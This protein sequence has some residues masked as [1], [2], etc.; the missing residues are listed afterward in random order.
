MNEIIRCIGCGSV[1]QSEKKEQPG[2]LPERL[3]KS[4]VMTPEAS[5]YCQR[6]FRLRHYNEIQPVDIAHHDF[7]ALLNT[8]ASKKALIVNVVDLFDFNNSLI[9]SLKRFI[10]DNDLSLNPI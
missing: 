5:I 4:A 7:L 6:C 9:P 2:Y 10:G 3:L 8:L 1:L